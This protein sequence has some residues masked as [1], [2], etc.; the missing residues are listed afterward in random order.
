MTGTSSGHTP[1]QFMATQDLVGAIVDHAIFQL[2]A[3]GTVSSWSEG[4]RR[5]TGHDPSDVLGCSHAVF[6]TRAE[7][8]QGMPEVLLAEALQRGRVVNEGWRMRA[9]G[10]CF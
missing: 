8:E 5:L 6:F 4:C 1:A 2:G 7:R 9:D 10:T 3:R